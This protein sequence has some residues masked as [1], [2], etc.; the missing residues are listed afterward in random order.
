MIPKIIHYCWFG[1]GDKPLKVQKCIKSWKKY[2]PD[3]QII[4]WN[5]NNFD[6][7]MSKYTKFCYENKKYAFLSD[8]VRLWVIYNNGGIYMDTD[9]EVIRPL[10]E[11]TDNEAYFGFENNDYV[12]TGVG[13]G[14]EIKNKIVKLMIEEYDLNSEKLVGCP[15]LNTK[16]LVKQGLNLNGQSQ[17]INGAKIYPVEYFNPYDSL[18]GKLKKTINTYTIH[19]YAGSWL[20]KR[21]KIRANI[22][23]YFHRFFGEDCF[24]W[25]KRK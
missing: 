8:F 21:K 24:K 6:I 12:N 25:M 9:V 15:A 10:D 19:W 7:N 18:T 17:I 22:S 4:E 3:Y 13:F 16:A 20:S 11:L 2:C 1:K 23:K 5:E 14:A